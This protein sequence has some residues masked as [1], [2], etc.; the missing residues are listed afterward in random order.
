MIETDS[1]TFSRWRALLWPI[2]RHELGKLLPM[3]LM[4]FFI[5]LNY[6]ILRCIK[7]SLIVTA[8]GSGAEA[9][10]FIKV[11]A[12]FPGTLFFT[13]IYL[14][15]SKRLS[16]EKVFYTLFSIFLGFFALFGF[17]FYPMREQFHL[18]SFADTL[19]G[20]LPL[21][22]KGLIAMIRYWS[23]T[24][25]YVMSELWGNII[26]FVL[27]WGFANQIT[28][29]EEAKRFYGTFGIGVNLSGIFSGEL[30]IGL[31]KYATA[32]GASW[33]TSLTYLLALVSCAG[34]ACLIVFS[35]LNRYIQANPDTVEK[36]ASVQKE[37]MKMSFRKSL[38]FILSS[39]YMLC[40]MIMV[41]SYNVIINLVEVLWKSEAQQLYP[42]MQSYTI[43]MNEV[44]VYTGVLATS[45]SLF[46]SS[47][48]LRF[49]GWTKTAMITPL[50]LIVTSVGFFF[51][52]FLKN[53]SLSISA[54]FCGLSPLNFVVF[55]GTLQNCLSR[56]SKY[57]VFDATKEMAYIPLS[58]EEKIKGKA[59]IDGVFNRMGKS[60]GSFMYQG[61]LL[62]FSTVTATAPYVGVI[63]CV[64][65]AIWMIAIR[66]LGE[67]LNETLSTQQARA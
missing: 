45:I 18:H 32:H 16:R 30:S 47:N 23:F 42:D 28:K 6:N 9:I 67:Q 1:P 14:K 48:C 61:L 66:S 41:L 62:I 54:L 36:T 29:F 22:C 27:F 52:F 49:L 55:F 39:R 46:L 59:A 17:L 25:F 51:F 26:L 63:L 56:A 11:W 50:I 5:T 12:M 57:T 20:I 64:F 31:T 53:N 34:L 40:L 3:L 13:W 15:L 37:K 38:S 7:D 35:Y 21:G 19:T 2:H 4:F 8:K 65:L 10:P 60:A 33:D 58:H 44:T 24:L 43:F